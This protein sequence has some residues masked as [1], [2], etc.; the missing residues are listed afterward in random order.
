V[1]RG[2]SAVEHTSG[3]VLDDVGEAAGD[4]GDEVDEVPGVGVVVVDH[5][6]LVSR[7]SLRSLLNHR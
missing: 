5:E 7:R 1:A 6:H 4:L 3:V 2:S